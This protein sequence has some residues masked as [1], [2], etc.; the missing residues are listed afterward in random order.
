MFENNAEYFDHGQRSLSHLESAGKTMLYKWPYTSAMSSD[1]CP[2]TLYLIYTVKDSKSL[3]T[4]TNVLFFL[5]NFMKNLK[6]SDFGL[7][8]GELDGFSSV[9]LVLI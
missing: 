5:W 6:V 1:I 2:V 9:R 3:E 8:S 7:Q 4:L